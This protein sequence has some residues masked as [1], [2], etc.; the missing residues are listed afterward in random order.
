M[1]VTAIQRQEV[2]SDNV[3]ASDIPE[4]QPSVTTTS[5]STATAAMQMQQQQHHQMIGTG[6]VQIVPFVNTDGSIQPINLV[7]QQLSV[8]SLQ[9][10]QM[11]LHSQHPVMGT[12]VHHSNMPMHGAKTQAQGQGQPQQVTGSAQVLSNPPAASHQV[13]SFQAQHSQPMRQVCLLYTSPSPR[14]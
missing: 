2:R 12:Q 9:Q 13:S 4:N 7:P 10:F 11:L 1:L 8:S 14:D 6:G 5:A 3:S